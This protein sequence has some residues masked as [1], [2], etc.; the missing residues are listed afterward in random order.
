MRR[1][2]EARQPLWIVPGPL[3]VWALHFMAC[4]VTAALW[5]G[6]VA[7]RLGSLGVPRTAIAIYTVIA[8]LAIAAIGWR[9]YR[10]HASGAGEP[11]HDEDTPEDRHRFLGLAS[12]LLSGLAAVAVVYSGLTAVFIE[13]CQ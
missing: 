1:T 5:C 12:L 4:Y 7:G 8:L 3:V 10:A 6:R 11:P 13:T 2:A 9:G